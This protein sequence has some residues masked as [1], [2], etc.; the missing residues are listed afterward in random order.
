M[1][2]VLYPAKSPERCPLSVEPDDVLVQRAQADKAAFGAIYDRYLARIYSYVYYRTG[3]HHDAE[4]L[5]ARVFMQALSHIDG[6]SSR[7]VP[8]SAWLFRIAHNLVANWHRDRARKPSVS[9]D[10]AGDVP[11]SNRDMERAEQRVEIRKAIATLPPDRQSLIVMKYVDD[12]SNAEIAAVFG[13][14]E[15]AVKALLHRTLR[16]LRS[17]LHAEKADEPTPAPWPE[18]DRSG[19]R[20][21]SRTTAL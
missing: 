18:V 2:P 20:P 1:R 8:F 15:G 21:R 11:S 14:T 5:T 12:L 13:K 9:L 16:S 7:G 19:V 3:N 6:Y 17:A 4:D 10:A